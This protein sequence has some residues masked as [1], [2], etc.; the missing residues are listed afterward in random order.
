MQYK[1]YDNLLVRIGYRGKKPTPKRRFVLE[2]TILKKNKHFDNY[3]V[4]LILP[5]QVNASEFWASIKDIASVMNA[6]RANA[7]YISEADNEVC[8]VCRCRC[9][10]YLV[11]KLSKTNKQTNKKKGNTCA[12]DMSQRDKYLINFTVVT[13]QP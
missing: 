4:L 7:S 13:Q 2:G 12:Y 11:K 9:N 8:F 10:I 5:C 6:N 1:R 3:K